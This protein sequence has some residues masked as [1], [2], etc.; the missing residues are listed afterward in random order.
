MNCRR[1]FRWRD[2]ERSM[3]SELRFHL[4]NQTREYMNGG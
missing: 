4:E 2:W 1:W 3:D